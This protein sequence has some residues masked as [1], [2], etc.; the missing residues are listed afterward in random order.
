MKMKSKIAAI[1]MAAMT[2]VCTA[3]AMA[4][5]TSAAVVDGPLKVTGVPQEVCESDSHMMNHITMWR[6]AGEFREGIYWSDYTDRMTSGYVFGKN[7][8]YNNPSGTSVGDR[9]TGEACLTR[10]L[11]TQYFGTST[12]MC[13][14]PSARYFMAQIGDQYKI[15]CGNQ[16]KYVFVYQLPSSANNYKMKVV[17]VVNNRVRYDRQYDFGTSYLFSGNQSWHIEYYM[18]PI[19]QGDAS[20]DGFVFSS[21]NPVGGGTS[22]TDACLTQY[23][24]YHYQSNPDA[25]TQAIISACSVYMPFDWVVDRNDVETI[26][27]NGAQGRMNGSYGYV[28]SL[29]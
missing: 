13:A 10:K 6:N 15:K 27:Y 2:A 4:M 8:S 17:E 5:T 9:I 19:K 20:C 18:R 12:F 7:F 22:D 3:Q 11:A 24:N 28:A 1:A 21:Y 29:T 14:E 26:R 23:Y 16:T 25:R